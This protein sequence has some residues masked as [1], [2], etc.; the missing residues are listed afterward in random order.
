MPTLWKSKAK[1]SSTSINAAV[2][3]NSNGTVTGK[4]TD[5]NGG[6]FN[7]SKCKNKGSS[8]A[9]ITDVNEIFL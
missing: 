4:V 7:R 9:T 6:I 5:K 3:Q 8:A 2:Q 1:D